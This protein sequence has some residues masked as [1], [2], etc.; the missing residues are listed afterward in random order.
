MNGKLNIYIALEFNS[1]NLFK[2]IIT[3]LS[4]DLV[5]FINQKELRKVLEVYKIYKYFM[6]HYI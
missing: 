5:M 2:T 3:D 6:H 1:L 4:C